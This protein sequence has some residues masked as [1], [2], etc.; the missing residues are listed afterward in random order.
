[1]GFYKEDQL[2]TA[3]SAKG[4]KCVLKDHPEALALH[5]ILPPDLGGC[6][7]QVPSVPQ[8]SG[9]QSVTGKVCFESWAHWWQVGFPGTFAY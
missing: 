9:I 4:H 7:Q 5:T 8:D 6:S 2:C 1:M 3:E